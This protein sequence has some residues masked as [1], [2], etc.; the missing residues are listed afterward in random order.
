MFW[1]RSV[2]VFAFCLL[3]FFSKTP[4]HAVQDR[5]N[6][7]D[8]EDKTLFLV[9]RPQLA[10]PIFKESVALLF[11]SSVVAAEGLVIGFIIN[12]PA[13]VALSD[14]FPE[15]DVL[16]NRTETVYFGG[17]VE[18]LAPSIIFRSSRAIS[19]ATL[20]FGDIYVSFDRDFI[21][22][23]LKKAGETQD[24]HLFVGRSQWA[25]EQLQH[26]VVEGAWDSVLAETN[27]IFSASPQTLWRKLFERA[28]PPNVAKVSDVIFDLFER[29]RSV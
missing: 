26:E 1:L 12:R 15:D 11:P 28:E 3:L 22:E 14:V 9:A 21:R 24:L 4:V 23:Q 27:L 18:P 7:G 2:A 17:P 19:H 5:P 13:R 29:E 20:L 10:D 8:G 25:P 6:K 16:K